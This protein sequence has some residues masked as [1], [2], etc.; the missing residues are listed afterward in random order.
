MIHNVGFR[1]LN[2]VCETGTEQNVF[3]RSDLKSPDNANMK[4]NHFLYLVFD[5]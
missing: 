5:I 1:F 2:I 4:Y 3:I